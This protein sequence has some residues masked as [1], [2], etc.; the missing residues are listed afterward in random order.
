MSK[1]QVFTEGTATAKVVADSVYKKSRLISIEVEFPR[2][3]LAE[4]NTHRIF[5]R[6]SASSR[7][8]P[9]WKRL[10]MCF[11]RPYVP[12]SF[13]RNKG[14]MQA[15]TSLSTADQANTAANWL[16]GRDIAAIQAYCL[17]G[18][19]AQIMQDSKN[20]PEALIICD[21]I[22]EGLMHEYPD[23]AKRF[24]VLAE[25]LHKQHANRPLELYSFHTVIVTSSN[26]RNFMG[27]RVSKMAQ[28]E[29]QDFGIA[30]ARA[31]MASTPNELEFGEWHLPYI[32]Q[33]D[34]DE[35]KDQMQLVRI[36]C[37][38]CART[39]YLTHDGVRSYEEDLRLAEKL[40]QDG[41]M[42][43]LEHPATPNRYSSKHLSGNFSARW[44]QYRQTLP[45]E[46][47][48]LKNVKPEDLLLGCRNDEALAAF[49]TNYKEP[50]EI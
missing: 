12:A 4:F 43:P 26:W 18:G 48:F 40:Q 35:L 21:R 3:Y 11:D 32:R 13:G 30:I 28:P 8:I 50:E 39:S 7:A 9:V 36:S 15:S 33:D 24:T 46:N 10:R 45:N 37:G 31:I 5:T 38:R 22:E 34:R 17:T 41:H 16:V 44:T 6:N 20:H 19:R 1:L 42:S 49:I 47:D 2:P 27:L 23:V 29:A 14:G 25:P